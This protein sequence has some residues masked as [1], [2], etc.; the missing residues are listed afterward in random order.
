M[1]KFLLKVGWEAFTKVFEFLK[2]KLTAAR[3]TKIKTLVVDAK[4]SLEDG[5]LT[6]EEV[7]TLITDIMEI[8]K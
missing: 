1:M 5:K 3:I 2:D 4:K 6:Q 8:V 7:K